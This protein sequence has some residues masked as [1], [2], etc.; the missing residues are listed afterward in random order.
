MGNHDEPLVSIVMPCYNASKYIA[1]SI[2]SV[3]NQ[4]YTNWELIIVDDCSKD[5]SRDI[6]QSFINNDNR[7]KLIC[8]SSPSGSPATPRN[9]GLENSNGEYIA[10]LDSDDL[11]VSDKLEKQLAIFKTSD[12]CIVYSNYEAIEENGLRTGRI[13][14]EPS[15]ANYRKLLKYNCIGCSEAVF[16]KICLHNCKFKKIGHEDYLFWLSLL[17][18]GGLAINT[19]EV[20]LLYRVRKSS[21]SGNKIRAASWTWNIYRKEL[22][23]SF[24]AS[25][26][27]FMHYAFKGIERRYF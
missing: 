17:K 21:V 12:C 16:K 2:E 11:W 15:F 22:G 6:I 25:I 3:L 4:T 9:I 1:D 18:N 19:N 14:K 24:F 27:Y 13:I 20:H 23:L 5:N 7:I 10:F 8:N 26:Y